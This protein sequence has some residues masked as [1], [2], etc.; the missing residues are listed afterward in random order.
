MKISLNEAGR[1]WDRD[2]KVKVNY[3]TWLKER[4]TTMNETQKSESAVSSPALKGSKV[5]RKL[6]AEKKFQIYREAQRSDKPVG[7]ILRS[8]DVGRHENASAI[9]AASNPR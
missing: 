4:Q 9:C 7:D 8:E 3:T 6:S 5:R 2:T 1:F